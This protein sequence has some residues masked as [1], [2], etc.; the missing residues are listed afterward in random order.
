MKRL[1]LLTPIREVSGLIHTFL[2]KS[3]KRDDF[4]LK[5]AQAGKPATLYFMLFQLTQEY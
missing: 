2:P 1:K 5:E 4:I 3:F